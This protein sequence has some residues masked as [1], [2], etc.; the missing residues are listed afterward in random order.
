MAGR[1]LAADSRIRAVLL[2]CVPLAW[3]AG[4]LHPMLYVALLAGSSVLHAW[5]NAGRYALLTQ[6]LPPDQR[7]T[8]PG[9]CWPC[10]GSRPS[11]SP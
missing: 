11:R 7:L 2:G 6:I 3:A 1:L 9:G 5:G 10:R 8:G 4:V